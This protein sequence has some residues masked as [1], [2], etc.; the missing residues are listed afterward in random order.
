MKTKIGILVL[1]LCTSFFNVQAQTRVVTT[2]RATSND[3]SDNLDLNAVASIFGDSENLEDFERQLN[4]PHNRIS[5]LDLNE[6]GYIDYLRVI[7]TSSERNSLV[8][9]QAVLD[10]DIY[11]DVATIEIERVNNGSPRIQIVGD[12]YIYGTNYIIEPVFYRTPLIFSF[13]WGPRYSPWISPYHWDYYPRWYSHYRPYSPFKY[14]RHIYGRINYENKYHRADSRIIHFP[15]DSYNRIRRDDYANRHPERAFEKR[16]NGV[17]NRYELNERRP[18][19]Q[20]NRQ[21]DREVQRPN[22]RQYQNN[23]QSNSGNNV[24]QRNINEY[25]RPVYQEKSGST[26]TQPREYDGNSNQNRPRNN[27]RQM[28]QKT[29]T[30]NQ[31]YGRHLSP[32][33]R[34]VATPERSSR[35]V[36]PTP[37]SSAPREKSG[38][39]SGRRSR[40]NSEVK[41]NSDNT[42]KSEPTKTEEK[43]E[44]ENGRRR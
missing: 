10:P 7:E 4:D 27:G 39:V 32:E 1:A 8:V 23:R 41:Q 20:T 35:Q 34:S 37:K 19:S 44:S 9:I 6:D 21:R 5:N 11:Q 38:A 22:D 25:R 33:R 31:S 36:E 12:A 43:K 29:E 17:K 30:R 2:T 28:Q 24:R 15:A 14:R 3:I 13:F 40:S 42:Q 18:S 26:P 16:N